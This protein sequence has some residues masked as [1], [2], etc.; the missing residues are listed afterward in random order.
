MSKHQQIKV[1]APLRTA[2]ITEILSYLNRDLDSTER[3]N[4]CKYLR[5]D[6]TRRQDLADHLLR[7]NPIF[8]QS[9]LMETLVNTDNCMDRDLQ[10]ELHN[11]QFVSN[12]YMYPMWTSETTETTYDPRDYSA[13]QELL[14]EFQEKLELAQ[15]FN[16]S[17]DVMYNL[18][19][20]VNALDNM[21]TEAQEIFEWYHV[22]SWLAE[23]LEEQG[24]VIIDNDFGI[25]WGRGC[26]G[27]SVVLDHCLQQIALKLFV[28]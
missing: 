24:E 21:T 18:E 14:K 15:Q 16:E 2:P 1:N 4:I 19:M 20:D 13:H 12:Y 23:K 26:T 25:W 22:N 27:Q 28:E 7:K 9:R 5:D 8:N 11:E 6:N 10:F 3:K 17:E